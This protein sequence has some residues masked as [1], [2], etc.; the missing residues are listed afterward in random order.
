[1]SKTVISGAIVMN[2]NPFTLG[3]QYLIEYASQH[4]D[5]LY[6]FVVQEDKSYFKFEDR[7]DL[8][9]MGTSYIKNVKVVPSGKFIISSTTF[10]EYFDK[11][12]LNGTA[13]DPSLDIEIFGKHIA[14]ALNI[15]VRFVGEEPIDHVTNQYNISMKLLLPKYGIELVQIPRKKYESDVISASHVRQYIS[16]GKWEEIRN[17]VPDITYQF[18]YKNYYGH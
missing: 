11:E 13:I 15:S 12:N 8:V 2:C 10:S 16:E 7:F 4:V 14:P 6:V 5:Y 1:M 18:L 9:K 3:H 17:I